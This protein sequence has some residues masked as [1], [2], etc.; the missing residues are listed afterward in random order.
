MTGWTREGTKSHQREKIYAIL[1]ERDDWTGVRDILFDCWK[2][3]DKV[4]NNIKAPTIRRCLQELRDMGKVKN[5]RVRCEWYAPPP[6]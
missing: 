2:S 6:Q 5:D 3:A 1:R 4:I